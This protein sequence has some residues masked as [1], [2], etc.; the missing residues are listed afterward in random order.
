MFYQKGTNKNGGVCI[1]VWKDLKAT[2]I[3]VN[4]PN[5]VVI[6]IADLS[7]PIRIIGIYWPTSQQRDL[8]EILPYVVDGT[9]LS[10]DF[11]A[12]VKEWNSPITD[13][14]GAHVKEW[15]NESNLDYIPSTSN[16]SK[17]FL[18]NIDSSFSNMSTISSETLFFG[19]SDHWP[20]MLSCENIFFPHTNW[21]AFEAVITLLQTFWMREQKKNSADE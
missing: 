13:R 3:E 8:D 20:I 12:T 21:K 5:I 7:Q 18:R 2:R 4:I 15:I 17:R 10:G 14:R 6:D 11:N 9:I 16:S 19:T 1:A